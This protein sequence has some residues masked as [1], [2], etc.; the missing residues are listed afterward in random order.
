[1]KGLN[2]GLGRNN[3][4]CMDILLPNL[5]KITLIIWNSVDDRKNWVG[6]DTHLPAFD[7]AYACS[8]PSTSWIFID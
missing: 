4:I 5:C 1:M 2:K 7:F 3:F 6:Y 8:T